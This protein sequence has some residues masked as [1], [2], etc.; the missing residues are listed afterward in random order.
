MRPICLPLFF[1][2]VLP[3]FAQSGSDG[4]RSFDHIF[5]GLS[6]DVREAA[7]SK[8]GYFRTF[9]RP[10]EGATRETM[11]FGSR[12][13]G[14]MMNG[15]LSM[16]PVVLVES[17]MVVPGW[18]LSLLSAYNALARIG[19]LKGRVYNSY[20]SGNVPLFEE[21]TRLAD[22]GRNFA[23]A[24][25][26]PASTVPRSE[27][28]YIRLR[29]ANFGNTFYRANMTL[30]GYGL[31]YSLANNRN[32]TYLLVPVIREGKFVAHMYFEPI[33]E[34]MLIY[35]VAGVDVSDFVSSK[36]SMPSAIS[37]RLAVIIGWAADGISR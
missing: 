27:T 37:K 30:E 33:A 12:L 17:V 3:A 11:A 31:R 7:F 23:V 19:D 34:G 5:P 13:D 26:S 29:D 14:G 36:I 21:A 25:P 1:A 15:V 8:E 6:S 2:A 28:V 18:G 35:G 9:E 4:A 24:D 22:G 10:T 16:R 32:I 20:R